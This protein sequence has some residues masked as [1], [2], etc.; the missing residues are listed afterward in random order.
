MF[1]KICGLRTRAEVQAAVR[2]GAD[3]IGF[4]FADSPRQISVAEARDITQDV[5]ESVIQVAVMREPTAEEWQEVA[6]GF[7]PDCLQMEAANYARISLSS[8]ISSLPVYR[9]EPALAEDAVADESRILFEGPQSGRGQRADW[10]VARRLARKTQLVLAGG[11]NADN[12][13]E[14]IDAVQPWGVDVSSG[15]ERSRGVKDL[16]KIEAFVEAV[17]NMESLHADRD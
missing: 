2:A 5:P 9:D 11:L 6:K 4:V 10:A 13:V 7:R 1:I 15:V 14:A 17:R 3:A 12:V 16:G 8:N